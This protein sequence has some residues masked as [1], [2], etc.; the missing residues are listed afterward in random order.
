MICQQRTRG[1]SVDGSVA[2]LA[3]SRTTTLKRMVPSNP[4]LPAPAHVVVT[5]W[6]Q[7]MG[8]NNFRT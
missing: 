2:W 8:L 1:M 3:S 4:L 7:I 5:T 6:M